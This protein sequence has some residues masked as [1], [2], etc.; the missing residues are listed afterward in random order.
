MAIRPIRKFPDP[1]LQQKSAPV[2]RVTQEVSAVID[3]LLDMERLV[4]GKMR[5]EMQVQPLR[6]LLEQAI[7]SNQGYADGFG[8]RAGKIKLPI[9][10]YNEGRDT[11]VLR[12][13]VFLPQSLYDEMRRDILN[14]VVGA[15]IYGYLPAGAAGSIQYQIVYGALG[16]LSG[17]E[18]AAAMR[19]LAAKYSFVDAARM[20]IWGWS[21]GGSSTLHAMFRFSDVYKVGVA[22]APM[23]VT[24]LWQDDIDLSRGGLLANPSATP[25]LTGFSRRAATSS[26]SPRAT[27]SGRS[28]APREREATRCI[29]AVSWPLSTRR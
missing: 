28:D 9:G 7:R 6:P 15:G 11:D 29:R 20:G 23:S 12:P 16:D 3:D 1:L 4:A 13:M 10:F 25:T 19:A 17:K 27:A 5:F 2:E 24:L 18:Q 14:A 21:G 8:V 26:S 22:V